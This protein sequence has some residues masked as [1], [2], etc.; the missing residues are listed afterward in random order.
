[1]FFWCACRKEERMANQHRLGNWSSEDNNPVHDAR[2]LR[3]M[4]GINVADNRAS[5]VS[6]SPPRR[7]NGLTLNMIPTSEN[8]GW[9]HLSSVRERDNN[10]FSSSYPTIGGQNGVGPV[11]PAAGNN[12]SDVMSMLP[13][14][15]GVNTT[16]TSTNVAATT[17]RIWWNQRG[18]GVNTTTTT[19]AA[20]VAT[21]GRRWWNQR[22]LNEVVDVGGGGVNT[23][24]TT[25]AAPI[26][27]RWLSQP[28][29]NEVIDVGGGGV[30]T[31]T[32]V[33]AATTGRRWWNQAILNEVEDGGPT[34]FLAST[35]VPGRPGSFVPPPP[36]SSPLLS[37]YL[38]NP[39]PPQSEQN[40]QTDSTLASSEN[41]AR[42]GGNN[43]IF[44]SASEIRTETDRLMDEVYIL[45]N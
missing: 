8:G 24:T 18:G 39:H 44:I 33:A 12:I 45:F 26:G 29:L 7:L 4:L 20:V 43:D 11:T 17:G 6:S 36:P 40:M 32:T 9:T 19:D 16:I 34:S 23:T 38:I 3:Y 21:T 22:I 27:R 42:A 28:I 10:P 37:D 14:G 13:F 5:S 31:T 35:N 2:S 25:V 15:G 41:P 30:N 1:M